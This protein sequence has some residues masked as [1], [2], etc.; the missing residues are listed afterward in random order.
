MTAPAGQNPITETVVHTQLEDGRKICI[1]V[2]RA[3]DELRMRQGIELLSSQSRYLRFFSVAPA[4][5]DRVIAK[6]VDVDG[7]RHL[8]WGAI[9]TDDPANLAIGAVHAVRASECSSSAE[10]AVGIIDAYHGLGLARML[11]A[12]LLVHCRSEGIATM[13]VQILAENR[14]AVSLVRSLGGQKIGTAQ[15]VSDYTLDTENA[16][17]ALQRETAVAGLKDVFSSLSQFI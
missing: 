4:P 12:V 15:G 2:V 8:A 6:L 10:F 5:P 13:D 14:A 1:R 9:L 17:H 7:H 16:L 3:S 11:T